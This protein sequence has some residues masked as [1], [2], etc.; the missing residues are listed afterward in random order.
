M[1]WQGA[2]SF[3]GLVAKPMTRIDAE[4]KAAERQRTN[5]DRSVSYVADHIGGGKWAV[6]QAKG[7]DKLIVEQ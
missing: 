6:C 2:S 5:T 3:W 7:N 4:K 1:A